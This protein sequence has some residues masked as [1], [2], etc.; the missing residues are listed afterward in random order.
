MKKKKARWPIFLYAGMTVFILLIVVLVAA[1]IITKPVQSA[2][3]ARPVTTP[4]VRYEVSFGQTLRLKNSKDGG[5]VELTVKYS[6][7]SRVINTTPLLFE[8]GSYSVIYQAAD[9]GEDL[10]GCEAAPCD[11]ESI[12][13][14]PLN[15]RAQWRQEGETLILWIIDRTWKEEK[16]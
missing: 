14:A 4:A 6:P 10:T 16:K 9:E 15:F 13:G 12:K 11:L 1:W 3:D 8:E 2:E 7:H 5:W